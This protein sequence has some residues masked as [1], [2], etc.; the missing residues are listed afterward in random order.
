MGSIS[1]VL[2]SI[3]WEV[4]SGGSHH[5]HLDHHDV[6]PLFRHHRVDDH[7][8]RP[9]YRPDSHHDRLENPHDRPY[10]RLADHHRYPHRYHH[11]CRRRR[12]LHPYGH[13]FRLCHVKTW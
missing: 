8:H 6:L 9:Y 13:H 12:L 2:T 10:H 11:L 7:H 3:L 5:L 4:L 1:N